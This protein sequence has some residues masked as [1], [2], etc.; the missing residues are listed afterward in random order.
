MAT[1]DLQHFFE[2]RQELASRSGSIYAQRAVAAIRESLRAKQATVAEE[3]PKAA[4]EQPTKVV[5]KTAKKA[6]K[7][8]SEGAK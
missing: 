6:Q 5:E 8:E 3:Q 1:F 7:A 2:T 4:K